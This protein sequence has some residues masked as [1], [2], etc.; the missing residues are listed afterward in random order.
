MPIL[1]PDECKCE[2]PPHVRL[3]MLVRQK[4]KFLDDWQVVE[5]SKPS[6]IQLDYLYHWLVINTR[7][8][9]YSGTKS[10]KNRDDCMCLCPFIDYFN[11]Q[12]HGVSP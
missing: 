7:S 5:R 12:D 1:W 11:H 3:D 9:Y 6:A 2:L 8:L 4:R 10:P